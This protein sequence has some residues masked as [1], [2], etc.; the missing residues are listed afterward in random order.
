MSTAQLPAHP[1]LT[2]RW[3][4]LRWHPIQRQY[5]TS[6][7]RFNLLPCGRRSGKTENAKRKL[8]K[9]TLKGTKFY[10][11]RFFAGAPTREQAKRIFWDDLK[12]MVPKDLIARIYDGDLIIRTVHGSE[13]VVVGLDKPQRMEGQAWDG[14][15][16]DEIANV[17]PTAWEENIRPV[18][19]D[20]NGWCD[21]I[22]VPEG[23]NHYYDMCEKARAE[24]LEKGDASEWGIFAWKSADILPAKEIESA[25]RD[26][27]PL[28]Y[29][30]EYEASF[31][32]FEGRAY[33]TFDSSKHVQRL[34]HL[35]NP[36]APLIV[37]LDFNVEPGVAAI[38]Q[39]MN[40]PMLPGQQV[41]M[42][43]VGVIGEVHIPRNSNTPAVA[44]RI[45]Q[46]WGEHQGPV[47]FYG[48]A[49]GGN[50]GTA[51]VTG[52]DWD[53]VRTTLNETFGR[54]LEFYVPRANP[55]ERSRVNS[56]NAMLE[57]AD[58]QIRLMVDGSKA[59]HVVRDF[60][61]VR[62]LKGGS[63]E[64]DKKAD[65]KLSHISDALGYYIHKVFPLVERQ[66]REGRL[67]LG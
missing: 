47:R 46:D 43:G 21:L 48:D 38:C 56:V 31:V 62:V 39:V 50:R 52:S 54:R 30:Q 6:P 22:G 8:V 5:W 14:G 60:D 18:L 45:A 42:E 61:G 58:G 49:T 4:P 41:Q 33:Y 7:H 10:P 28:I 29:Q 32:S 11:A 15:V 44:R 51:K 9:A 19:S 53:L 37:C 23:R 55:P 25:K 66:L 36:R 67:I 34:A 63:G 40:L 17:K 20:R 2:P 13:L 65:P 59:P 3:Y 57:N 26:M 16:I 35:Y 64:I 1:M 24:M 12:A 27:D